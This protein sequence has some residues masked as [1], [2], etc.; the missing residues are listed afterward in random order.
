M[1]TQKRAGRP[2]GPEGTARRYTV[3]LSPVQVARA[4]TLGSTIN[5]GVNAALRQL[6]D[7]P[8]MAPASTTG[9]GFRSPDRRAAA[10]K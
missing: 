3:L 4:L 6:V 1:Q 5:Q 2:P 9:H 7:A 10:V 8:P